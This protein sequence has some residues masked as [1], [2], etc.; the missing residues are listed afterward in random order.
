MI[1]MYYYMIKA[2]R[3]TNIN[4]IAKTYRESVTE[5]IKDYGY[6]VAEDGIIS[7]K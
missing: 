6:V 7:K 1:K 2:G 3:V 5:Y 4:Q